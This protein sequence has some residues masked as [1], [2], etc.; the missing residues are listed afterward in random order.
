MRHYLL[1][2]QNKVLVCV[3][4]IFVRYIAEEISYLT[5]CQLPDILWKVLDP[6]MKNMKVNLALFELF[7]FMIQMHFKLWMRSEFKIFKNYQ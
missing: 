1:W 6:A 7:C 2:K 4:K 5:A 3:F